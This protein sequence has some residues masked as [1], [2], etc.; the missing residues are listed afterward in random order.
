M[1]SVCR[2]LRNSVFVSM[3]KYVFVIRKYFNVEY[4]MDKG[5][6]M[7]ILTALWNLRPTLNQNLKYMQVGCVKTSYNC[8]EIKRSNAKK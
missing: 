5:N 7:D 4:K 6:S 3:F 2:K 8:A 1:L